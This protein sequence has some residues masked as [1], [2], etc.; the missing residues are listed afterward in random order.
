M[1][2]LYTFH[3][4]NSSSFTQS[5]IPLDADSFSFSLP[6]RMQ[7][8]ERQ[9][10]HFTTGIHFSFLLSFSFFHTLHHSFIHHSF[11]PDAGKEKEWVNSFHHPS[12]EKVR[13]YRP[14]PVLMMRRRKG[15]EKAKC[16]CWT[17][18]FHSKFLSLSLSLSPFILLG[19]HWITHIHKH[20][21]S[22]AYTYPFPYVKAH[23]SLQHPHHSTFEWVRVR[24]REKER[25]SCWPLK[26]AHTH[27]LFIA[28]QFAEMVF[29]FEAENV[30][31]KLT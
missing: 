4:L 12:K 9:E 14:C 31:K 5:S 23:P 2:S 24:V 1:L 26:L 15:R 10:I 21:S 6:W 19:L 13:E 29:S 17:R 7:K 20:L 8:D 11:S 16:K 18:E 3:I 25:G 27:T 22:F 30:L 28:I